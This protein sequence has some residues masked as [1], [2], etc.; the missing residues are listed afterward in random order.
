LLKSER[1]LPLLVFILIQGVLSFD[2]VF[3]DPT[4]GYDAL[5]HLYYVA[6]LAQFELPDR[7]QTVEFFS[8]PL[9]Y[10]IPAL[11][12]AIS[13]S[14]WWAA[15]AGQL[16]NLIFSIG[17]C[18]CILNIC[19]ELEAGS[20]RLQFWSLALLAIVPVY[21]KSFS[22]VRGEPLLSLMVVASVYWTLRAYRND[23]RRATDF[24]ILGVLLG[25]AILSRQWAFLIFPPLAA[26][27]L[28]LPAANLKGHLLNLKPLLISFA[29]AALVGGWFYL[30]LNLRFGSLATFSRRPRP[31]S[32]SNQ[33]E[34]FYFGLGLDSLFSDPIRPAFPDEFIPTFYSEFWGDYQCYF[35]VYARYPREPFISGRH[36]EQALDLK[37]SIFFL[38]TNRFRIGASLGRAQALAIVPSLV[39]LAGLAMGTRALVGIGGDHRGWG[40]LVMVVMSSLLGYFAFAI[41]FPNPATGETIKATY[42][43]QV[44]PLLAILGAR[45]LIAIENRRPRLFRV[46]A[47][48][49]A[50][51][52]ILNAPFLFT[53]YI[54]LPW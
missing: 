44:V 11:V 35:L 2:V 7:Y 5:H 52:G 20:I 48:L 10:A 40:L 6:T 29:L 28:L 45:F 33:P 1:L 27:V 51:S 31:W 47:G 17:L 34:R 43:L 41:R 37:S 4:V 25:L 54:T 15:K 18:W 26:F 13:G 50:L 49:L 39:F 21:Y 8:P 38:T 46:L 9:P 36:L 12:K 42:M 32:L 53:R 22:M 23:H 30:S 14:L 19:D 3:H 24:T 16:M